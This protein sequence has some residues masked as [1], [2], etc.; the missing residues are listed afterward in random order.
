MFVIKIIGFTGRKPRIKIPNTVLIKP[1]NAILKPKMANIEKRKVST[2]IINPNISGLFKLIVIRTEENAK[3]IIL[4]QAVLNLLPR[5]PGKSVRLINNAPTPIPIALLLSPRK[6]N[7]ITGNTI[8]SVLRS[9][10]V[11]YS[12]YNQR[13]KNIRTFK[14]I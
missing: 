5:F 1:I 11:K 10:S 2:T 9:A 14:K 12:L 6:K 13:N 3:N 4:S 7:R 8:V